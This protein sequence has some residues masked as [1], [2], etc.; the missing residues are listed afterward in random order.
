MRVQIIAGVFLLSP[1]AS[2]QDLSN[3]ELV[4]SFGDW[5][6]HCDFERDMGNTTYFD[7]IVISE[8]VPELVIVDPANPPVDASGH[9]LA[10]AIDAALRLVD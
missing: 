3:Y 6:V 10:E 8:A 7:C 9:G 1:F 5:A 2:A 4:E